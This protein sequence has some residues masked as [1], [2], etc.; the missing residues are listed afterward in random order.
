MGNPFQMHFSKRF[1][2]FHRPLFALGSPSCA[3]MSAFSSTI[4]CATP[5]KYT[6]SLPWHLSML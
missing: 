2:K 4:A 6:H 3:L 1:T 5:S